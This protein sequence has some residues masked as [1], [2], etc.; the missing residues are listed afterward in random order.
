MATHLHTQIRGA[1]VSAL[2]GLTTSA[3]RVYANRLQ[4]LPDALSPSLLV[5]LDEETADA[6]TMVAPA[7]LE[8][9]LTVVVTAVAKASAALDDTLDAMG[10]EVETTLAAGITV[11]GRT[12]FPLYTGMTFEDE[13]GDKPVGVRRMTFSIPYTAMSNAPDVLT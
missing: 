7:M 5:T 13:Q 2:T 6:L 11:A 4:P 10:K 9:T 1:V 12:L 8:R 3:G